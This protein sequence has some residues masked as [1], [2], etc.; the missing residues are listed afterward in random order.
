MFAQLFARLPCRL[1]TSLITRFVS[2]D[3]LLGESIDVHIRV[4][5]NLHWRELFHGLL[6]EN[7]FSDRKLCSGLRLIQDSFF[8]GGGLGRG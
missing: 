5:F 7:C 1:D 3:L 6:S 2:S 4:G 8:E